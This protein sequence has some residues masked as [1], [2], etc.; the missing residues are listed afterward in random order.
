MK[1]AKKVI[2]IDEDKC[3][4]CGTCVNA[5]HENAIKLVNGKAKLVSE[6]Y[7]DG[8]GAYIKGKDEIKS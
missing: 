1:M 7:C 8:L 6:S 5:C 3:T 2:R 4:G